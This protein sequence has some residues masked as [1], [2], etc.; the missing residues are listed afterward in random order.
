M[1]TEGLG[2]GEVDAPFVDG[3]T[4]DVVKLSVGIGLVGCIEAVEPHGT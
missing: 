2:Y 3:V 1:L 4:L